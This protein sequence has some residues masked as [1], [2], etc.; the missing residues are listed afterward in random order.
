MKKIFYAIFIVALCI[1]CGEK[2]NHNHEHEHEHTLHE[3]HDHNHEHGHEHN[4]KLF[5][6]GY[7]NTFEIYVEA[8]PFVVGNE[9]SLLTHI[10]WLSDF[11]PLKAGKITATLRVGENEIQNK[12]EFPIQEGIF[13]IKINPTQIGIGTLTFHIEA[14]DSI[15][16]I[17]IPKINI[18]A[19]EHEAHEMA[20]AIAPKSVN[21]INF[22]KEQGWEIDFATDLPLYEPFGQTIKTIAQVQPTPKDDHVITA[23]SS[24]IVLL[25]QNTLFSGSSVQAGQ[26]LCTI[27][28]QGLEENNLSVKF[29]E[30]QNNFNTAKENYERDKLLAQDNI[31]SQKELA[32]SKNAYDNAKAIYDNY[33]KYFQS[34]STTANAPISGFIKEIFVQNGSFVEIGAPLITISENRDLILK[35]EIQQKYLPLM[36]NLYT[37]NIKNPYDN[38]YLSLESLEGKIISYGKSLQTDSYLIPITMQIRNSNHFVAGE[39]VEIY[40]KTRSSEPIITIPTSCLLEE[41]GTYYILVQLTPEIFEKREVKIGISDGQRI[42]IKNGLKAHERVVSRGATIVKLSQVSSNLDPHAGHVH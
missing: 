19:D 17:T 14:R 9:S 21:A 39:L 28:S 27:S 6:T 33:L 34:G 24:G 41:Q 18:Y 22:T 2:H 31:V 29:L 37:A 5:L 13:K 42:E 8:D 38:N 23:K 12:V 32:E 40:L 26:T 11:K 7:N 16:E 3:G 36:N 30:A 10:T 20:E 25:T 15:S 1:S 4:A 35:A